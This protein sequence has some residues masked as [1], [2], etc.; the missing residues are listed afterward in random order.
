[1]AFKM[2]GMKFYGDRTRREMRQDIR[3]ERK[4]LKEGGATREEV[5]EYNQ[6]QRGRKKDIRNKVKGSKVVAQ[7]ADQAD[8]DSEKAYEKAKKNSKK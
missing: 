2:N 5:K 8:L 4:S 6:Y 7:G 3:A 1:M